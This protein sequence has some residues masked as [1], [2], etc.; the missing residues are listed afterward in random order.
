MKFSYLIFFLIFILGC[1]K[2]QKDEDISFII[3]AYQNSIGTS[4]GSL[5]NCHSM[6]EREVEKRYESFIIHYKKY[7]T[8]SKIS[9]RF[10]KKVNA[11]DHREE[12]L[13]SEIEDLI[14]SYHSAFDSIKL[15]TYP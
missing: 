4:Y 10:Y 1:S 11:F 5:L 6:F 3:K 7:Q 2:P 12:I 15:R 14:K 13:K 8:I 9:A